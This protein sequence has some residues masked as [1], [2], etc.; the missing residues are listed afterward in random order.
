[1]SQTVLNKIIEGK[2][3]AIVLGIPRTMATIFPSIILFS[4]V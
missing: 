3:V 2:I 1:M 4:T